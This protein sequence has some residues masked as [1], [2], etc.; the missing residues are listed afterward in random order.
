MALL[1][2]DHG[3]KASYTGAGPLVAG[4]TITGGR[5]RCCE[6]G[7]ELDKPAG[8]VSNLPVCPRCQH[9]RWDRS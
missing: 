1:G 5:F 9:D 7:F 4:E 2:G 3:Q 6:C 8:R